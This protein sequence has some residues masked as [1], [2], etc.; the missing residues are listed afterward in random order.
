MHY[1]TNTATASCVCPAQWFKERQH[2]HNSNLNSWCSWIIVSPLTI[3]R[4]C[5]IGLGMKNTHLH[6]NFMQMQYAW[7]QWQVLSTV[8]ACT[9][10]ASFSPWSVV[11][12]SRR[13]IGLCR[14]VQVKKD[15]NCHNSA[16]RCKRSL[17]IIYIYNKN[18]GRLGVNSNRTLAH[19]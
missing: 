10:L 11:T 17:L 19:V 14:K 9:Y 7:K 15:T 8:H 12:W 5:M 13:L 4:Y 6:A 2:V 16:T 1:C 3:L 18:K